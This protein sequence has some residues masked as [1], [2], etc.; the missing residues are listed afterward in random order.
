M[1]SKQS[2]GGGSQPDGA[3]AQHQ[4]QAEEQPARPSPTLPHQMAVTPAASP[5]P[6][7]SKSTQAQ[8]GS[9]LDTLLP[10]FASRPHPSPG[11]QRRSG[12]GGGGA[13]GLMALL[14]GGRGSAASGGVG[15]G[16]PTQRQT[17]GAQP[18]LAPPAPAPASAPAAGNLAHAA[19]AQGADRGD[20]YA[21]VQ[22]SGG[23]FLEDIHPPGWCAA[24][25]VRDPLGSSALGLAPAHRSQQGR[26][27]LQQHLF[28]VSEAANQQHGGGGG[29]LPQQQQQQQQAQGQRRW[30]SASSSAAASQRV[31]G[32]LA[33]E[34]QGARQRQQRLEQQQPDGGAVRGAAS[35]GQAAPANRSSSSSNSRDGRKRQL[36]GGGEAG[37]G[38]QQQGQLQ[39]PGSTTPQPQPPPPPPLDL[40]LH[41]GELTAA[42]VQALDALP[43]PSRLARLLR[44]FSALAAWQG[45]VVRQHMPATWANS[46][47]HVQGL[48]PLVSWLGWMCGWFVVGAY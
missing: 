1:R 14:G 23:G 17:H 19:V 32:E 48:L 22:S 7:G 31:L 8:Q 13:G 10:G 26:T 3:T 2:S 16:S 38:S 33:A 5:L 37:G 25:A 27:L 29:A 44:V 18:P 43:L 46:R 42:E 39:A 9:P 45:F 35:A 47:P 11:Q 28:A 15:S 12:G 21:F 24:P 40:R 4:Q 20:T 36:G 41:R 34:L 6:G 30:Y